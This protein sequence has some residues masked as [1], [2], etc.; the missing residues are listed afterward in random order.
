MKVGERARFLCMPQYCEG[1]VQLEMVLRQEKI[2]KERA[3]NGLPPLNFSGCCA[4]VSQEQLDLQTALEP[5]YGAPVEFEFELI[6]V[7]AP[8]TF[9]KQV[10]EMEPSEKYFAA[11]KLK[12][13][14][15]RLFKEGKYRDAQM[16]YEQALIYLESLNNSATVLDLKKERMDKE[17]DAKK[18]IVSQEPSLVP[19]DNVIELT[20]LEE[21][22]KSCRLN[23]AAC[24]LKQGEY[25]GAIEQCTD[26]LKQDPNNIKAL[27]RRGQSF[28]KLGRDLDLAERDFDQVQRL[29]K[30]DTPEWKQV[31][32]E[33]KTLE[34]KLK[35][36][37]EKEKNMFSNIFQ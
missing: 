5:V 33:R 36:H 20:M 17:R 32:Q 19:K 31:Q 16:K 8:N 14:G 4:N 18:G 29:V 24:Q 12:D 1:F 21:L 15:G 23:R 37:H 27:F 7:Q 34:Q 11:P 25:R 2:N 22:L 35:Q 26:I 9:E 30:E 13:E 6:D 28:L 10:W 3:L